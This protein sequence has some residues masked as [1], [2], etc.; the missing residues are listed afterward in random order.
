MN[1]ARFE[2]RV[3]LNA[4]RRRLPDLALAGPPE[5]DLRIRFRGF[6]SVPGVRA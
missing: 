1:V 6:R 4:L 5:R 2:A 3:A